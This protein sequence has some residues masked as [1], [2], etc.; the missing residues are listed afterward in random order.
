MINQDR[1]SEY[2]EAFWR[3][4]FVRLRNAVAKSAIATLHAA[5]DARISAGHCA[6]VNVSDPGFLFDEQLWRVDDCVKE[7]ALS[8]SLGAV[9]AGLLKTQ[10]LTLLGDQ[11]LV[12][13]PGA[14]S[15]TLW[16]QDRNYWALSGDQ[17]ASAWIPLDAVP[18]SRSLRLVPGSHRAA[19]ALAPRH[20]GTE[21]RHID[22][23]SSE[24]TALPPE[25]DFAFEAVSVP[26][27]VGDAIVFHAAL[28]HGAHGNSSHDQRRRAYVTRWAGEDVRFQSRSGDVAIPEDAHGFQDGDRLS[29]ASFPQM[30]FPYRQ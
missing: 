2:S 9:I 18:A 28:V 26:A 15:P 29:G 17:L 5:I 12:K 16:H 4:G 24:W 19:I 22:I 8:R 23:G 20:F 1:L 30:T 11:V 27:V 6:P 25:T 7:I 14:I 3:D 10:T 13:E 21:K